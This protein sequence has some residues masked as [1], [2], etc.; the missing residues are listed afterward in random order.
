MYWNEYDGSA[1][2]KFDGGLAVPKSDKFRF[3]FFSLKF[4]QSYDSWKIF[5]DAFEPF[6]KPPSWTMQNYEDY[7]DQLE[8]KKLSTR[9]NKRNVLPF[10]DWLT[11]TKK[12]SDKEYYDLKPAI[13]T[14]INLLNSFNIDTKLQELQKRVIALNP[15]PMDL[16]IKPENLNTVRRIRRTV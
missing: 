4:A 5:G 11:K 15:S 1:I 2:G 7:L 9:S 14:D 3:T 16:S 12:I 8:Q 13:K 10:R 6:K